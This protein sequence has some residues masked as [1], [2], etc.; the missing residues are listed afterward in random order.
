MKKKLLSLMLS[1]SLLLGIC[2]PAASAAEAASPEF[3]DLKDHWAKP[4]VEYLAKNQIVDGTE[5]DGQKLIMPNEA[6]SRAEFVKILVKALQVETVSSSTYIFKDVPASHWASSYVQTAKAQ[7][8][9]D[10]YEDDSFKP[11]DPISR[12]EMAALLV[13]AFHLTAPESS[14]AFEDLERSHWGYPYVMIAVSHKLIEGSAADGKRLFRP[15]DKATR[16]EAMAVVARQL[17]Q[18]EEQAVAAS[19]TPG[20]TPT[21]SATP[22]PSASPSSSSGGS[23]SKKDKDD[24]KSPSPTPSP[25]SDPAKP[26]LVINGQEYADAL[27]EVDGSDSY[28]NYIELNGINLSGFSGKVSDIQISAVSSAT[29]FSEDKNISVPG[30]RGPVIEFDTNGQTFTNASL[31]FNV[32]YIDNRENLVAAYYNETADKFEFLP[33][34]HNEDGTITFTTTHNSKYVLIDQLAWENTFRS[35]LSSAVDNLNNNQ[36]VDIAFVIDSSGSMQSTDPNNY[37]VEAVTDLV[38]GIHYDASSPIVTETVSVAESVYTD[39]GYGYGYYQYTGQIKTVTN[40]VYQ[41]S[42]RFAVID[43]DD[44]AHT[45]VTFSAHPQTVAEAVYRIDSSG[46]TD[47]FGGLKLGIE[48]YKDSPDTQRKVIILLTDGMNNYPAT[49]SD[50]AMISQAFQDNI[51]I[52]TLG[53]S[54]YA[55]TSLLKKIAEYSGGQY[56]QVLKAEDLEKYY[57]SIQQ[58]VQQLDADNDGLADFY[59]S[60]AGMMLANGTVIYTDSAKADTDGD[61]FTD[62]EEMGQP[63]DVTVTADMMP[64]G[65]ANS[66]VGKTIKVFK[67]YQSN[68]NDANDKPAVNP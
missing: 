55:D 10:G 6:V 12:V 67:N 61:G 34:T 29:V 35:H 46:G 32:S 54:E 47:I 17:Q 52:V 40:S 66:L 25:S 37:R 24:D 14:L 27:P 4:Y 9:V 62:L 3:A 26:G 1:A 64:D 60:L 43:F 2:A 48:A 42:D 68:P 59:E 30:L 13:R 38:Y 22:S 28:G 21:P 19:P 39:Y 41:A 18:L 8:F 44:E 51:T 53:L 45:V 56:F 16:A 15:A 49:E 23:S 63:E 31:M 65:A 58:N 7:G 11:T 57:K 50:W 33:T 5:K 36:Y 20:P